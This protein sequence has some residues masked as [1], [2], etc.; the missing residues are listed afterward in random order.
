MLAPEQLEQA[1]DA[2]T[3]AE[4]LPV[5]VDNYQRS[6]VNASRLQDLQERVRRQY[7]LK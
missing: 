7:S 1:G 2:K 3:I 4:I 5:V 6:K